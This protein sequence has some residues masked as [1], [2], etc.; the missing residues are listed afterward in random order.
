MKKSKFIV[1]MLI[2]S[3][4]SCQVISFFPLFTPEVVI[5]KDEVQGVFESEDDAVAYVFKQADVWEALETKSYLSDSSL[6]L[7]GGHIVPSFLV[8]VLKD[9]VESP[10]PEGDWSA[11]DRAHYFPFLK[12]GYFL[13]EDRLPEEGLPLEMDSDKAYY[14]FV[15]RFSLYRMVL[16]ELD[17]LVYAD[18]AGVENMTGFRIFGNDDYLPVHTFAKFNLTQ[19]GFKLNYMQ[20]DFLQELF[21]QNRIRLQHVTRS[22]GGNDIT[23]LTAPTKDLQ[24]F[25]IKFGKEEE[26]FGSELEFRRNG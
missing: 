9:M 4:S 19:D 26:A 17:G 22:D 15:T 18:L 21:K 23:L 8:R 20:E 10:E 11:E 6:H 13:I 7:K 24:E 12:S 1:L 16:L 5:E 3:I 14:Q 25:M 2:L